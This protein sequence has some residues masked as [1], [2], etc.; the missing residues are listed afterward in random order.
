LRLDFDRRLDPTSAKPVAVAVSGGGDSI[1][2][3]IET[4]A[5]ARRTGRPVVALS[6]DHGLQPESRSWSGFV[7][8]VA[9]SLG[10]A[11]VPLAWTDAKPAAGL[12]AA[13][14]TARHRLIA[15]AAREA[16][17]KVIVL[18]HTADDQQENA[19]L[20]QGRLAEWSP[21]PVWPEGRDIFVYRP[22]LGLSRAHIRDILRRQSRRWIDD[23]ANDDLRHPRSR[24][25]IALA[26]AAANIPPAASPLFA[27][28]WCLAD[29]AFGVARDHA[30][31]RSLAMALTCVSGRT[32]PASS[33]GARRLADRIAR[34]EVFTATLAGARLAAADRLVITRE[35][36]EGARGGLG[37]LAL[38]KGVP[39]VWDGRYEIT[40]LTDGLTVR[41][42]GGM[43]AR[44]DGGDRESLARLSPAAR[45]ASPIICGGHGARP[46]LAERAQ[47]A[48]RWLAPARFLAACG[49]IAH[50]ADLPVAEPVVSPYVH[51]VSAFENLT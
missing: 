5:W 43:R 24:V 38:V 11:F 27:A 3:L 39:V 51:T 29:H 10:C 9:A 16:G 34:G 23:P 19:V 30:C 17:A 49:A 21:S 2:A 13:A 25:R 50:E 26:G 32:T 28:A 14:R 12:A 41:A 35:A 37:P 18:G 7:G 40:A 44:L 15:N 42:A 6:V 45:A 48:M 1:F 31:A 8:E 47:V 20:G 4:A 36:G 33:Q 22:M 46:V